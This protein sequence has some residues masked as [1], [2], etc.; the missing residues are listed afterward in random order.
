MRRTVLWVGILLIM[1]FAGTQ[2]YSR[3]RSGEA[4]AK[5]DIA[6]LQQA[7]KATGA[8]PLAAEIHGWCQIAGRY[9][10]PR[11]M[12]EAVKKMAGVFEINPLE[13]TLILRS[14][15][16]YGYAVAD[17]PLTP[18]VSVRFQVQSVD[19][20]TI[21][22]VELS[23]EH[24]RELDY[25][26]QQVHDAIATVNADAGQVKIT[27]CLTGKVSAR[28]RESDKLNLVYAAFNAV[29][30]VYRQGAS[31]GGSDVWSG[32]SPLFSDAAET[33]REKISFSVAIKRTGDSGGSI[34]RVATPVLPGSY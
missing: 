3:A 9:F 32:F 5:D 34:V 2:V 22:M 30:A 17:F 24:Q 25:R 11:E 18:D 8:R 31:A 4:L 19:S 10:S 23:Q 33:A 12:E 1:V 6:L 27:S 15:G 26:W 21:A 28:L 16:Q 29:Q 14:T 13:L 7:L 20:R